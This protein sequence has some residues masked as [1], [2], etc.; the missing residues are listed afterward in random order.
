MTQIFGSIAYSG[1]LDLTFVLSDRQVT[2]G[3]KIGGVF[4]TKGLE[5]PESVCKV[6]VAGNH[7]FG[8]GG[9]YGEHMQLAGDDIY[10]RISGVP[11]HLVAYELFL[12]LMKG[13]TGRGG[14]NRYIFGTFNYRPR[15]K[16]GLIENGN[17]LSEEERD[18][19]ALNSRENYEIGQDKY[20]P[21][22]KHWLDLRWLWKTGWHESAF[23]GQEYK[24]TLDLVSRLFVEGMR[25]ESEHWQLG[26]SK[27][28]D[29]F[30]EVDGNVLTPNMY[31]LGIKDR[32]AFLGNARSL[33]TSAED[34]FLSELY[35]RLAYGAFYRLGL[36]ANGPLSV[37]GYF[38]RE[39]AL[40]KTFFDATTGYGLGREPLSEDEIRRFLKYMEILE[41][42]FAGELQERGAG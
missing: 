37:A 5:E 34:P 6:R 3:Y 19:C 2:K 30:I 21:F 38:E 18:T 36:D 7:I 9:D 15:F 16:V 25:E 41:I 4:A 23:D 20:N 12:D 29:T 32:V 22:K 31:S 28:W 1:G 8:L 24:P 13:C 17:V 35:L 39:S 33:I 26:V 27:E 10:T 14:H 40:R 42:L 11:E